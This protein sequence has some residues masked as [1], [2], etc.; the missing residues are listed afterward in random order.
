MEDDIKAY[1]EAKM[2]AETKSGHRNL[3][4]LR[5]EIEI[6][7]GGGALAH[8]GVFTFE[9]FPRFSLLASPTDVPRL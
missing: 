8:I 6:E 4:T 5:V 7:R 9:L 1:M 2:K 3:N